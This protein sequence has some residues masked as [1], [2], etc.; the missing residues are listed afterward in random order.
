MRTSTRQ[1]DFREFFEAENLRLQRFAFLLIG[2]ADHAADLAQEALVRVYKHWGRI[3]GDNPGPYARRIVVNLIRSAH[4]RRKVR[5][6]RP[7]EVPDDF[8][9][10]KSGSVDERLRMTAALKSLS[11]VRRATVVM[12]FYEDMTE[13]Q[14][15]VALDRPL[16]TVK[17]D[18]HRALKE[19][20]PLLEDNN[21]REMT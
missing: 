9:E 12:R 11:P 21:A 10:S 8:V 14:I 2:D 15:S 16:G 4:R 18:L 19:L 1:R 17:S 20:R 7:I 6:L 5:E 13:H 3:S